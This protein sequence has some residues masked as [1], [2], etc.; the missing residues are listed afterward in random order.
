MIGGLRPAASCRAPSRVHDEECAAQEAHGEELGPE[1]AVGND[2]GVAVSATL[3]PP[4][5]GRAAS[6]TF[7]LA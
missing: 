7:C 2:G 1:V 5:L 3:S 4:R 6:F